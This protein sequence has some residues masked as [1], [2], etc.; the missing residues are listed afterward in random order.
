MCEHLL[1]GI[2]PQCHSLTPN[3]PDLRDLRGNWQQDV[4][5]SS[6]VVS[7][8]HARLQTQKRDAIVS[9]LS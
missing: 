5:E 2:T 8:P 9:H 1:S 3:S 4:Q 7:V 6:N